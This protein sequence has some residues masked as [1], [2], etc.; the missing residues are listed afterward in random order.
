MTRLIASRYTTG[1][2][3]HHPPQRR[4]DP[5]LSI[6]HLR[7]PTL[8]VSRDADNDRED[9]ADD[10]SIGECNSSTSAPLS[11]SARD[12]AT[13]GIFEPLDRTRVGRVI[14]ARGGDGR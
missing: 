14:G 8:V 6:I 11:L 7:Y 3:R 13:G 2:R 5:T 9:A 12:D 4:S 1:T 10:A